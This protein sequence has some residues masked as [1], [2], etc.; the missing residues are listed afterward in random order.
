MF[1]IMLFWGN[2]DTSIQIGIF[3][4]VENP[5]EFFSWGFISKILSYMTFIYAVEIAILYCVGYKLLRH[6]INLD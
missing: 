5:H 4:Q 2:F 3:E 6:G 1:S